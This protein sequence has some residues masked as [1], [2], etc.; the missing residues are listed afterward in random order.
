MDF[1]IWTDALAK[2]RQRGVVLG[3]PNVG[4]MV[5]EATAARDAELKPA[6]ERRPRDVTSTL[7]GRKNSPARDS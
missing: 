2:A 3:N 5:S 4:K 1:R 7:P 6:N